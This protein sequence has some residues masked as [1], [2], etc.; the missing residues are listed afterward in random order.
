[1][2][3]VHV[4][5]QANRDIDDAA[6][7]YAESGGLDLGLQFLRAVE[8]TWATLREFPFSGREYTWLDA[9][10]TGIRRTMVGS[11]FGVYLVFYRVSE[12]VVEVVRV[13]HGS[14]DIASILLGEP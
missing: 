14:R 2:R 11:P 13:L 6:D 5:P 9:R 4:L 12:E 3:R 8:R 1:V 7:E 10:L